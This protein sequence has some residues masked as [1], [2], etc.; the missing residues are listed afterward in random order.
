[1]KTMKIEENVLEIVTKI[2]GRT[3]KNINLNAALKDELSLDSIQMVE[4][5]ASLEKEFEIE[6]P[7]KMMTVK[8]GKEFLEILESELNSKIP[9]HI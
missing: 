8:T 2:S 4:L 5:F 9:C 3:I 6:L 7:L 1:M